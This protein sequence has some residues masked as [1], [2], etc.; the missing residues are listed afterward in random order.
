MNTGL[1]QFRDYFEGI[2]RERYEEPPEE[3]V[4]AVER[5]EELR[6]GLAS[7]GGE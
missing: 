3:I 5:A 2:T 1:D 6:K 7:E 4:R